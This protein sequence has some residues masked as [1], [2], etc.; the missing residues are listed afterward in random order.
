MIDSSDVGI[1]V[2]QVEERLTAFEAVLRVPV[3]ETPAGWQYK[4]KP[5]KAG[6]I[7]LFETPLYSMRGSILQIISLQSSTGA[8]QGKS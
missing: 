3:Q 6:A 1:G 2:I 8:G 7:F 5:V 4:A